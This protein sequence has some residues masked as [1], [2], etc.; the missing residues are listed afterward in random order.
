MEDNEVRSEGDG[1]S[2]QVHVKLVNKEPS[3]F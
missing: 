3:D 1:I 2:K